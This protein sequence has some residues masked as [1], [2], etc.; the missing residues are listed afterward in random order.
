MVSLGK[1]AEL[2]HLFLH[3]EVMELKLQAAFMTSILDTTYMMVS[4]A[5]RFSQI[6]PVA[7]IDR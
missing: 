6:V 7:Q 5:E 3:N 2:T 1:I 4:S